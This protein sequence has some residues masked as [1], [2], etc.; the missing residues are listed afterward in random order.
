MTLFFQEVLAGNPVAVAVVFLSIFVPVCIFL[1]I[2]SGSR[3]RRDDRQI[4]RRNGYSHKMKPVSPPTQP[5][6]ARSIPSAPVPDPWRPSVHEPA[7]KSAPG[8]YFLDEIAL[9][10]ERHRRSLPRRIV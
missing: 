3:K 1:A 10:A 6:P 7:A 9:N 2:R 4:S 5:R 8:T